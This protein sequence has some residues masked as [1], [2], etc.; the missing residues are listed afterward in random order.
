[1]GHLIDASVI[2]GADIPCR[3]FF[4]RI[5]SKADTQQSTHKIIA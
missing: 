3:E 2:V 4:N 5:R 1:M